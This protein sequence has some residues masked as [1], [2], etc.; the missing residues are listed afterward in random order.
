LTCDPTDPACL[1][2]TARARIDACATTFTRRLPRSPRVTARLSAQ[3][4]QLAALAAE[5]LVPAADD[6]P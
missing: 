5:L 3:L 6:A 4:R 1:S 2:E